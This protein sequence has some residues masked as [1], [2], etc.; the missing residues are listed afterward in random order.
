MTTKIKVPRIY[1]KEVSEK[2][3]QLLYATASDEEL[4]DITRLLSNRVEIQLN[5]GIENDQ[6]T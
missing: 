1:L 6:P 2:Y 3:I 4:L 5:K